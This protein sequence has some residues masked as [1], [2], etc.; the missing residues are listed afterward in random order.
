MA[1]EGIP[2]ALDVRAQSRRALRVSQV[3]G[4]NTFDDELVL[5]TAYEAVDM[6]EAGASYSE[7][8]HVRGYDS[9]LLMIEYTRGSIPVSADAGF[10]IEIECAL[11]PQG[12]WFGRRTTFE[13]HFG[14]P[15]AGDAH[16][17]IPSENQKF[18]FRNSDSANLSFQTITQGHYMRFRP[19][20][21][22]GNQQGAAVTNSRMR[23]TGI[24]QM[25]SV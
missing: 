9:I 13:T 22:I 25:E 1:G 6:V 17:T 24:R 19:L 21:V 4:I 14:T 5:H 11:H 12:P 23:V 15:A 8:I 10:D 3:R 2:S 20:A 18:K 7:S 16:V